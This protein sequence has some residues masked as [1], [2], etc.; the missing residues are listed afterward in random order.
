M[1]MAVPP[2]RQSA[3]LYDLGVD[4]VALKRQV[5]DQGAI[6]KLVIIVEPGSFFGAPS[7]GVPHA[8]NRRYVAHGRTHKCPIAL[9]WVVML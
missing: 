3:V 1:I 7:P 6:G 8:V 9:G 4:P 5:K 2:A